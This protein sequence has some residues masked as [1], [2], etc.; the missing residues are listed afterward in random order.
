MSVAECRKNDIGQIQSW[1]A[2]AY[3]A[4]MIVLTYFNDAV[5]DVWSLILD[6]F[7]SQVN[8]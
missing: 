2:N 8:G 7:G 5:Y 4:H 3:R 6:D 1:L